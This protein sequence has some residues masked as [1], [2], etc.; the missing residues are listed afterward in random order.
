MPRRLGQHFL[1]GGSVEKLLRV[2]GPSADDV[3]LEIGPG[4]GALTLPLAARAA[5]V[6]AVE[7]DG[8]LADELAAGRPP[9]SRSSARMRSPPT[10]SRSCRKA[11]GSWATCPTTSAAR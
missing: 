5:R 7:I 3:F 11:D 1:R 4:H 2:I 9:T 10:C 6:V 8:R